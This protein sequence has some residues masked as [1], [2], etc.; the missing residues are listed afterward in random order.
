M[1]TLFTLLAI[2]LASTSFAQLQMKQS[3]PKVV[4]GTIKAGGV[5]HQELS[6]RLDGDKD[7]VYTL[8]YKNVQY[9]TLSDYESV[10]F[11]SDGNTLEELY[12]VMKSVFSSENAKNKEFKVQFT[13]GETDVI[14]SNFRQMGITT[15]MFYT[16]DGYTFIGEKQLDKLFGK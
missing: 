13:L 7:T 4:I 6:Y 10:S 14:V 11:N 16:K 12:K 3:S 5:L 2:I 9:R 1:R 8:M 15:A